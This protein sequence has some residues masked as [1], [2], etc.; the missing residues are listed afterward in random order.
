MQTTGTCPVCNGSGQTITK[1]CGTCSGLGTTYGEETI[2][3]DIPAGVQEGMQLSMTGKGNAGENGGPA[4][5]LIIQI[6]IEEHPE[7]II[8]GQS[9]IY[10]L[11]INFADACLGCSVEVP[12]IDGK[13]KFKVPAG[14]QAGKMFRLSGKG[15][16]AVNSYGR[17][18]QLI[19]VYVFTPQHL[20]AEEKALLEKIRKAPNFTPKEGQKIE[21]GFFEKVK[22]FFGE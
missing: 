17:G 13:A 20:S 15:L 1:K 12:T 22:G 7:L 9:V 4:G 11:Q 19:I 18:D 3:V 10:N 2:S 5:D 14:T 8:D 21:G 16:P 6:E